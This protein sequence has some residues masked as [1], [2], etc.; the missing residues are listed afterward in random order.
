M[1]LEEKKAAIASR[2]RMAREQAGLSQGQ[3][4]RRLGWHRPTIS[5]IEAGNRSVALEEVPLFVE[6]YGV[7]ASWLLCEEDEEQSDREAQ[8][9]LA[10]RGLKSISEGELASL[11]QLL[12]TLRTGKRR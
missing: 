1:S 6:L 9:A 8:I 12:R 2:F 5:G 4:A 10:A 11:L 7:S 3:V